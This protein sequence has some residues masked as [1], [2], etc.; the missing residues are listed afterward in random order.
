MKK[1]AILA[2]SLVIAL[3]VL[4]IGYAKWS[5]NVTINGTVNTGTIDLAIADIG[6]TDLGPD[7]QC[8]LGH[9]Q[10]GKDIA[11]IVSTNGSTASCPG[12][13]NYVTE[14]FSHVY[15]W[16][17]AG[18]TLELK[19]C[20]T[21]PVKVENVEAR[22]VPVT[23]TDGNSVDLARWMHFYWT[24]TDEFGGV[25]TGDG[26]IYDF[27]QALGTPQIGGGK[28]IT[29]TLEICFQE[30]VACAL[31]QGEF[32]SG[33]GFLNIGLVNGVPHCIMPQNACAS[34]QIIVTASQWN[35]V[36]SADQ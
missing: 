25:S 23:C 2:L 26:T 5:D 27:Q 1:I 31:F 3:G 18:F 36:P 14:T 33:V 12:F 30:E 17:K 20:G 22:Y 19:N 6:V 28:S 11:S 10:E 7:P 4:G 35:E 21:V 9:N 24:I 32:T 8:G 29:V 16:Y 13:Y 34:Y 15:P